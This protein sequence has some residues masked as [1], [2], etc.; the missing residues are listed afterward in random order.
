M[1]H[2]ERPGRLRRTPAQHAALVVLHGDQRLAAMQRAPVDGGI[3]GEVQARA[4]VGALR[5]DLGV[6]RVLR[7]F[8]GAAEIAASEAPVDHIERAFGRVMEAHDLPRAQRKPRPTHPAVIE[9][10]RLRRVRRRLERGRLR[11]QQGHRSG[12]ASGERRTRR[13]VERSHRRRPSGQRRQA[14]Q[15]HGRRTRPETGPETGPRMGTGTAPRK[16]RGRTNA[17]RISIELLFF[18]PRPSEGLA[19]GSVLDGSKTTYQEDQDFPSLLIPSMLRRGGIQ[20]THSRLTEICTFATN[21]KI[22]RPRDD[23]SPP[24]LRRRPG[25]AGLAHG[26]RRQ[27]RARRAGGPVAGAGAA[28]PQRAAGGLAARAVHRDLRARLPGQRR[29]RHR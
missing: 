10:D 24:R 22:R 13:R 9:P 23:A 12:I 17:H 26:D 15:E 29:R 27:R 6:W 7:R 2:V 3:D 25:D 18:D 1:E 5:G 11:A 16:A 28:G 21:P 19:A 14:A 4:Q 8:E 20:R